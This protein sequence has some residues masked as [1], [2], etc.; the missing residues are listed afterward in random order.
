MRKRLHA[1]TQPNDR[2]RHWITFVKTFD[3]CERKFVGIS[4][5]YMQT[6]NKITPQNLA[7]S[8]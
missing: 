7:P 2:A 8:N 6:S 3:F 4:C 1:C 5:I